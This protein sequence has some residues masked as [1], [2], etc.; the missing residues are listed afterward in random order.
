[1]KRDGI[2]T[3]M[4]RATVVFTMPDSGRIT[5]QEKEG[6]IDV[7]LRAAINK[8]CEVFFQE[9]DKPVEKKGK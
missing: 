7:Q 5:V 2:S 9:W 3:S 8:A 4:K 6:T 1:M